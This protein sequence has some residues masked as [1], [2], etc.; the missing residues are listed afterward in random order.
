MKLKNLTLVPVALCV[1]ACASNALHEGL[2]H[3]VN[4]PVEQA[5]HMLGLPNQ[6]ME[7]GSFMLYVWDTSFDATIPVSQTSSTV[8][9]GSV[10]TDGV[11]GTL[12]TSR[13]TSMPV[14]YRCQI[15][16]LVDS[17]NVV[18]HWEYV[19]DA[20]GCRKHVGRLRPL[21]RSNQ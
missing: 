4:E 10:G 14:Q 15:R 19:G 2:P 6:R 7:T 12:A 11:Y 21:A 13:M 18:R 3:L 17:S 8:M 9:T 1:N 20:D 16:L 5:F